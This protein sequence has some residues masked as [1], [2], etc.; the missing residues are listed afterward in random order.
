MLRRRLETLLAER[1]KRYPAVA[2]VGPRQCGKTTLA[3]SF[4]GPY[5]D[6][7]KEGDRVRLDIEWEAAS[8]VVATGPVV[9]DEAQSLPDVFPRLRAAI[10]AD[11]KRT[12]RFLISAPSHRLSCGTWRSRSP[13]DCR[14]SS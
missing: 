5:Y 2:L 13:A 10:D 14:S 8:A 3:R 6:L 12:G 1:L 4:T 9:L 11:R 7:E